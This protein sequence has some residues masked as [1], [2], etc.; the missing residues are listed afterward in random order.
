MHIRISIGGQF[1]RG[2]FLAIDQAGEYPR[3]LAHLQRTLGAVG[4]DDQLQATAFLLRTEMFLLITGLGATDIR[5]D[6]DLQEVHGP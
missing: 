3:V 5:D 6:P 1:Q 4:G 2:T